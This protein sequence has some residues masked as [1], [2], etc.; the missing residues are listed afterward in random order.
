MVNLVIVESPSKCKK[1]EQ[2]LGNQVKCIASFGH[3][4]RLTSLDDIDT[5]NDYKPTFKNIMTK[6][7]KK[8][9][10]EINNADNI[11]LATDDDRE[12][13]AIAY[14]ICDT[15]NLPLTTKRIKFSEITPTAIK[16]A[17]NNPTQLNL[18]LVNAAIARQVL[19]MLVGFKISPYL[20]KFIHSNSKLSAGRCQTPTL[21]LVYDNYLKIKDTSSDTV[22][23]CQG[24]FT[25]QNILFKLNKEFDDP[26]NFLE[27]SADFQHKLSKTIKTIEQSP[28]M[29]L[30]TSRLQQIANTQFGFSPK[31]TMDICQKLYESSYITYMRTD[32]QAYCKEFIDQVEKFVATKWGANMVNSNNNKL[33][34]K[35]KNAHESIRVTDIKLESINLDHKSCKLYKLIWKINCQS[36]MATAKLSQLTC[37][38]SAPMKCVYKYQTVKPIF[39][40]WQELSTQLDDSKFHYLN[41]IKEGNI[42]YNKIESKVKLDKMIL[43]YTEAN[44]INLLEKKG[45]GRPSTYASLVEKIKLKGYVKI[46]DVPGKTITCLEYALKNNEIEEIEIVRTLGDQKKKIVIQ[47]LGIMVLEFLLSYFNNIFDYD[48]TKNMEQIL[49]DIALGKKV[50]HKLCK[51]CDKNIAIHANKINCKK[52]SF[53]IDDHHE[54]LIG[55]WGPTVKCTIQDKVVFKKVKSNLDYDKL[56]MGK[57]TLNDILDKVTEETIGM[58]KDEPIN[59][60]QGPYGYYIQYVDFKKSIGKEKQITLE[61]AIRLIETPNNH[62]NLNSDLSIRSGKWGKYIFYKTSKM[63]KPKFLKLHEYRGSLEDK[64]DLLKWIKEKYDI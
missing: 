52:V 4:R 24:Y 64:D 58:Y 1:I 15:F 7:F 41:V 33:I 25:Q 2:I 20:W 26:N 27:L 12:G 50:W 10:F 62:I 42:K 32:S 13:E 5:M 53:K 30:S 16:Y 61:Q 43:N 37:K 60:K 28:P 40:G 56:K 11:Y 9:K 54:F 63:K 46:Q 36:L 48:Y 23:F 47:S 44:L 51:D 18:K 14:H 55:K 45:I 31:V 17:Y 3:I 21:R 35:D 29:P 34:Q 59:L 6:H 39:L 22:Y 38:I 49:D 57:Y 19:D 8:L